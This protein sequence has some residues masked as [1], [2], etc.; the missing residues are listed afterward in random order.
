MSGLWDCWNPRFQR[1]HGTRR[2]RRGYAL[3]RG[4]ACS[5]LRASAVPARRAPHVL[6]VLF[7]RAALPGP[8]G[9]C[10]RAWLPVAPG[11]LLLFGRAAPLPARPLF[12]RR[13]P[14]AR[15]PNEPANKP[16]G[17]ARGAAGLRVRRRPGQC[18]L[19]RDPWAV[20]PKTPGPQR[21]A[22]ANR[23]CGCCSAPPRAHKREPEQGGCDGPRLAV[24]SLVAW[25]LRCPAGREPERTPPRT[26]AAGNPTVSF[27]CVL[28]PVQSLPAVLLL[29]CPGIL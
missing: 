11:A 10:T 24:C 15:R 16:G 25:L 3:T 19:P 9:R 29:V 26:K 13:T 12:V 22:P 2:G 1:F 18:G 7:P 21:G 4:F 23:H 17:G 6:C 5:G 27:I 14:P 8:C 28:S 20:V